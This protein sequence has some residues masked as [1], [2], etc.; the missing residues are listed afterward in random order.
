MSTWVSFAHVQVVATADARGVQGV[1][2]EGSDL[3][4]KLLDVAV[5]AG[6]RH[7]KIQAHLVLFCNQ[8]NNRGRTFKLVVFSIIRRG[9]SHK[10]LLLRWRTDRLHIR[11]LSLVLDDGAVE[12]LLLRPQ[13]QLQLPVLLLLPVH[14]GVNGPVASSHRV[15]SVHD[16]GQ[17]VDG[18][19]AKTQLLSCSSEI[20]L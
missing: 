3:A 9:K 18:L 11:Q 14:L 7:L 12:L 13:L 16:L 2:A 8:L 6:Q 1:N 10:M 17:L 19:W 20:Y 5:F 15:P 4:S